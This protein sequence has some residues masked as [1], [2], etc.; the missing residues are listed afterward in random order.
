MSKQTPVERLIDAL[1]DIRSVLSDAE[2]ALGKAEAAS[3]S[4]N[5]VPEVEGK[6]VLECLQLGLPYIEDKYGASS[7]EATNVRAAI[8]NLE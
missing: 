2:Y 1:D 5:E 4:I 3:S 6:G 7:A 8:T